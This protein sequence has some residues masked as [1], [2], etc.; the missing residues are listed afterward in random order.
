MKIILLFLFLVS[1]TKKVEDTLTS[2]TPPAVPQTITQYVYV[3]S[4][5]AGGIA[6]YKINS[7][8]GVL[9][10]LSVPTV[11]TGGDPYDLYVSPNN[12]NLYVANS[13]SNTMSQFSI[14]QTTG[15]VGSLTPATISQSTTP[16]NMVA[17]PNGNFLYAVNG[18]NPATPG[19]GTITQY[20][21][22][23][24]G[25]LSTLTPSTIN[26][27]IA[28]WFIAITPNG[29]YAYM[30]NYGAYAHPGADTVLM[31][32]VDSPSGQLTAL[33]PATVAT[34]DKPWHINVH[35]NGNFVYL[36]NNGSHTLSA[37][38]VNSSTGQLSSLT[39]AT[40]AVGTT[41]I[42]LAI[43]PQGRFLYVSN[44]TSN[45]VSAFTINTATGALTL[46]GTTAVSGAPNGL[47]VDT[48]GKYLYVAQGSGNAISMFSID[49]TTGA[50]TALSPATVT[51][52]N[53]PYF[54][55]IARVV[56]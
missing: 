39:P 11:V 22:S 35:P 30:T 1:C 40:Y 47:E 46:I 24:E 48:D 26:T 12:K 49:Q 17:H 37:Y 31:Y 42:G 51:T 10:P 28:A 9:E 50:L 44:R 33:T 27:G 23:S 45:N 14:S 21:M 7:D 56:Q 4:I 34:Q 54:I 52:G 41:P 5:G 29:N 38:A 15:L 55:R 2:T 53:N 25:S 16:F 3:S 32:S 8:T 6:Q 18:G 19:P 13:A 36:V 43:D 20:A